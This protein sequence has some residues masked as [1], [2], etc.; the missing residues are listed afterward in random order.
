MN[1]SSVKFSISTESQNPTLSFRFD[2]YNRW[3]WRNIRTHLHDSFQYALTKWKKN[4][5]NVSHMTSNLARFFRFTAQYYC[6]PHNKRKKKSIKIKMLMMILDFPE[7]VWAKKVFLTFEN[8]VKLSSINSKL[9]MQ[10]EWVFLLTQEKKKCKHSRK[11]SLLFIPCR[12]SAKNQKL[13]NF[14][15]PHGTK[16]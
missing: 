4:S 14:S 10:V 15:N 7:N 6:T 12:C 5:L 1:V 3:N 8:T 16:N 11:F 2:I 9:R 13:Y